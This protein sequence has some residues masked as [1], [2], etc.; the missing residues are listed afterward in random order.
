MQKIYELFYQLS[1]SIKS[2][3]GYSVTISRAKLLAYLGFLASMYAAFAALIQGAYTYMA[4][5]SPIAHQAA[6][7]LPSSTVAAAVAT[8]YVSA[9]VTKTIWNYMSKGW[10]SWMKNN[11]M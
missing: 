8:M 11:G 1:R 9:L 5:M 3:F 2:R 4:H 6:L 7:F 10:E